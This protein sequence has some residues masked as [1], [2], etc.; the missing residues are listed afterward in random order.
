MMYNIFKSLILILLFLFFIFTFNY[1]FSEKNKDIVK[2][3]RSNI[4][5]NVVE[6]FSDLPILYN[7]TNDVIEFNS[8]FDNSINQNFKEIFGIFLNKMKKK[9]IIISLSGFKLSKDEI[10]LFKNYLPWGVILFSRNIK[11]F[12]Q[13]KRLIISIKKITKDKL[14]Y[15]NR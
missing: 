12:N 10:K 5:K 1:Y 11:D 9:A 7:D 15:L 4:E 14:S 3:N 8:G 6:N 13:L 2:K